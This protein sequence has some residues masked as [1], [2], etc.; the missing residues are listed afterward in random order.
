M[1]N[2]T[3]VALSQLKTL[4]VQQ[5]LSDIGLRVFVAPGGCSGFQYGMRFEDSAMEGDAI[6]QRDGV[7]LFVDEFSAQYL[8]GAEIDYVD[9]L[10]GGGFTIHNPNAI[11]SCSCGQS[12]TSAQD[13]GSARPCGH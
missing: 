9:E 3:D 12:F 13:G 4:M 2:L 7:R 11:T 8:Q 6:E 5:G 10:M 1:I